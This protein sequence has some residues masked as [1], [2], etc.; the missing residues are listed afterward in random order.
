M[1][2]GALVVAVTFNV[3]CPLL[4]TFKLFL[5]KNCPTPTNPKSKLLSTTVSRGPDGSSDVPPIPTKLTLAVPPFELIVACPLLTDPP[6]VGAKRTVTVWLCP[7]PRLKLPPLTML[8]GAVVLMLPVNTPPPLFITVK[9]ASAVCCADTA[10]KLTLAGWAA[11][12]GGRCPKIGKVVPGGNS[13]QT[14]LPV[15]STIRKFPAP[16]VC[17]PC[18]KLKL[19]AHKKKFPVLADR[20][21]RS[22][23]ATV[24]ADV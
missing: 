15:T 8:N 11:N 22:P 24:E 2:K 7:V 13:Q 6:G 3:P 17:P 5:S 19:V 4:V 16:K 21:S 14:S 20:C 12:C 1:L 18:S 9:L 10:P 23:A